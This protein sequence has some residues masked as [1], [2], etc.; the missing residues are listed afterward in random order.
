MRP[1]VYQFPSDPNCLDESFVYM[2]GDHMLVAS[3]LSPFTRRRKV[4]LPAGQGWTDFY[5]HKHYT[6]G[7]KV[8]VP[9]PLKYVP[10]FVADGGMIPMGEV[11]H[12]LIHSK[13]DLRQIHVFPAKGEASSSLNLREDDG[14]SLAYQRGEITQVKVDLH[15]TQH[16]LNF[17][18]RFN[19]YHYA[20]PYSELEF[21]LPV[22]EDRKV[23]LAGNEVRGTIIEGRLHFVA[24]LPEFKG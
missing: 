15:S 4:Y 3:V 24:P 12:P 23:I 8:I 22:G 13:D 1:L 5:T 2:L 20:L 21:I 14:T 9:A 7:Q 19:P 10:I 6:G 17:S 11:V 18:I 16:E